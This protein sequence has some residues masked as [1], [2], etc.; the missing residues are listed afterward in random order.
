MINLKQAGYKP[1]KISGKLR[2]TQAGTVFLGLASHVMEREVSVDES[3]GPFLTKHSLDLK[4]LEDSNS[5]LESVAG[6]DKDSL[7][8]ESLFELVHGQ[9]CQAVREAFTNCK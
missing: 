3:A 4:I 6:Y 2:S 7:V 8:G 1:L 5:L 9:D